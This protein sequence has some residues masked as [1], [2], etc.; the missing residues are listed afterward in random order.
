MTRL[1]L[2]ENGKHRAS[3]SF[4]EHSTIHEIREQLVLLVEIMGF[5]HGQALEIL[6]SEEEWDQFREEV[7]EA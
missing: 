4:H 3:L 5:T 1:E 7:L 6:P 2:Y